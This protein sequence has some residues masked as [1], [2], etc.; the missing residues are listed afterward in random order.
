MAVQ[1]ASV[2]TD[3]TDAIDSPRPA[4]A[5]AK[6]LEETMRAGVS[7]A[8]GGMTMSG[9]KGAP[10]KLEG[11]S[12]ASLAWLPL[13]GGTYA[14]ADKGRQNARRRIYPKRR[15]RKGKGH[16]PALMTPAGPRRSVRGSRTRGK[17]ITETY[18]PKAFEAA[19]D[20]A[21]KVIAA[22]FAK[23]VS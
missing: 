21:Q 22:D 20:A 10:V 9:F 2:I 6:A 23:A 3:I 7:S 12:K 15:G 17:R 5:A 1:L 19:V 13:S 16:P 18:A 14:L 4:A 11:E 8:I